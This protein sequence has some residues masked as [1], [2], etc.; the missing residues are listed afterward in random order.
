MQIEFDTTRFVFSHSRQPK[1]S[2]GWA[3]GTVR[4][5]DVA[6]R[7]EC[8]FAPG[9]LTYGEARKWAKAEAKRRF[10]EA[11]HVTLYVLS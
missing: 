7:D 4:T 6:N 9:P 3:F 5:P 1:G 10:P 11:H 2:G 8:W